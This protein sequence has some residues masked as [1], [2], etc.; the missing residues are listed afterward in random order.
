MSLVTVSNVK[1][2]ANALV[3][4]NRIRNCSGTRSCQRASNLCREALLAATTWSM[5]DRIAQLLW[6][7]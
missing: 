5:F 6:K 4:E 7:V 2:V 1:F 3:A